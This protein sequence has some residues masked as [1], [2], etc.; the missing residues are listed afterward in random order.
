MILLRS[1]FFNF[2]LFLWTWLCTFFTLPSLAMPKIVPLWIAKVWSKGCIL[3]L[4]Y[5][6]GVKFSIKG[7]EKLPKEAIII[8]SKHQSTLETILL[9]GKISSPVFILKQQLLYIPLFGLF[10]KKLGMIAVRNTKGN[11]M[12]KLIPLVETTFKNNQQLI[13]FPEGSRTLPGHTTK[14]R[15]GLSKIHMAFPDIPIYPIALN[16][17]EIWPR[18]SFLKYP[19]TCHI[20]ILAPISKSQSGE[21]LLDT[22]KNHI[23]KRSLNLLEKKYPPS[24]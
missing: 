10:L 16:T 17:G 18:K 14:Y 15:K 24:I 2:F 5:I 11:I 7:F 3:G 20:E 12:K 23:E 19:G 21:K 22:L 4:K 13:I 8:A 9:V 6:I 1:I